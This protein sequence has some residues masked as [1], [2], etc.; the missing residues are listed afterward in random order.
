MKRAHQIWIVAVEVVIVLSCIY[1][2]PSYQVRG[3]LWGEAFFNGRPTSY[4]RSRFLQWDFLIA[5]NGAVFLGERKHSLFEKLRMQLQPQGRIDEI[6]LF[7]SVY[8]F[9]NE[10]EVDV[11]KELATDSNPRIRQF[12]LEALSACGKPKEIN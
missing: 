7:P 3:V 12:A 10:D 8:F 11:L 5:D 6:H 9:G 1:H 4:W 2:E